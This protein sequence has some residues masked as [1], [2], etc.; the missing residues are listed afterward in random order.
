[1]GALC[2]HTH[3]VTHSDP[4][5]TLLGISH[6]STGSTLHSYC[7]GNRELTSLDNRVSPKST[8]LFSSLSLFLPDLSLSLCLTDASTHPVLP[9]LTVFL[10]FPTPHPQLLIA[11]CLL[12]YLCC[13]NST[14]PDKPVLDLRKAVAQSLILQSMIAVA[15]LAA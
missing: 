15:F 14:S 7:H 10:M 3:R 13:T 6:H 5:V 2:L 12:A 8:L 4:A 1:M 11:M 9:S